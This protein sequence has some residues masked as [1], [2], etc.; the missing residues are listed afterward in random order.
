MAISGNRVLSIGE[1]DDICLFQSPST[2]LIDCEQRTVVPGF[3]DAHCHPFGVAALAFGVDCTPNTVCCIADIQDAIRKQAKQQDEGTWINALGYNE[4]YLAEKRHP[5]RWDLDAATSRNP[6]RLVHRSGHGSVLNS[7]ALS[8][9]GISAETPEPEGALIERDSHTGEP[10]GVLFEME[11]HLEKISPLLGKL[12]IEAGMKMANQQFLA[13]GITSLQDASWTDSLNRWNSLRRMVDEGLLQMRI[14][15]MIGGDSIEESMNGGLLPR[16]GDDRLRVGAVKLVLDT[17]TGDLH[18]SPGDLQQYVIK[19][20]QYG[21][22][23]AIHCI[24]ED[25]VEAA[26]AALEHAVR[27]NP[28]LDHRHRLEHCSICPP[29]LIGR[30]HALKAIV[31]TQPSFIYYSG[32]RYLGMVP[33]EQ[34]EHLYPIGSWIKGDVKVAAASDAPIVPVAPLTGIYAATTRRE[35]KGRK[36]SAQ[37]SITPLEAL[38]MH[39]LDAAYTTFEEDIK[40]S[41]SP[42]KLADLVVLSDNPLEVDPEYIKDIKVHMTMVDG[43]VVWET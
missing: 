33:K 18:P 40:G 39:T 4:Y 11:E 25:T 3:I 38:R 7:L 37:H 36:I 21:S 24:E 20:H 27:N 30:I 23:V 32:D 5:T 2:T 14:S 26:I 15:M 41:L 19:A 9:S 13:H 43:K 22:Q 1:A 31:V 10:N 35:R 6:V 28:K 17:T 16:A 42:G 34:I 29:R 12:D 8:M